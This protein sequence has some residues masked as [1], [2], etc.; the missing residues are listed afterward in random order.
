MGCLLGLRSR[1]I[2]LAWGAVISVYAQQRIPRET[3]SQVAAVQGVLRNPLGLGLG[4]VRVR[5]LGLTG[6]AG[7]ET[8]TSGDGVFRI[9]G[10]R[11][12]RYELTADLEGYESIK[13]EIELSVGDTFSLE[14]E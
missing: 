1:A 9:T 4:G 3:P 6:G 13:R 14:A 12:G 5:L 11:P 7:R 2:V 10:L 8:T